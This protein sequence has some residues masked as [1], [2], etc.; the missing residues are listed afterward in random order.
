[1]ATFSASCV[2]SKSGSRPHSR[3]PF[4]A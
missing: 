3:P 2:S 1:V 4:P